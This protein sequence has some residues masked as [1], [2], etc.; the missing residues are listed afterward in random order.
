MPALKW[1]LG[2]PMA[3]T[4]MLLIPVLLYVLFRRRGWL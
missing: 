4:L 2:Y 1:V 3:L